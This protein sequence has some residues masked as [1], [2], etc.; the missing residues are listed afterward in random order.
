MKNIIIFFALFSSLIF[1]QYSL[2]YKV[3]IKAPYLVGS[4]VFYVTQTITQGSINDGGSFTVP[5]SILPSTPINLTQFQGL[6]DALE[7]SIVGIESG[8]LKENVTINFTIEGM[9]VD[10]KYSTL[11]GASVFW[12]VTAD[13]LV[14]GQKVASDYYFQNGKKIYWKFKKS[15]LVPFIQ[16]CITDWTLNNWSD[17]SF[18]YFTSDAFYYYWLTNEISA[19][20]EGDYF[21]LYAL[22]LSRLAGGRGKTFKTYP[23]GNEEE[24]KI[25]DFNLKQNYPNPFN[26]TTTIQFSIAEKSN[27]KLTITDMLGREIQTL[28]NDEL[29]AGS[30]NYNFNAN[31]LPSGVYF[32]RLDAGKFSS[33]KKMILMK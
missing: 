16:Q 30:Y 22:H 21:S 31:N 18:A 24:I 1:S 7:N 8:A 14:N 27:V 32:Y 12:F 11:Y 10:G 26:P 29:S 5:K 23:V 20:D 17:L 9:N 19:V 25:N 2:S 3:D 13:V 33:V 6:A 4:N 28:V 15:N